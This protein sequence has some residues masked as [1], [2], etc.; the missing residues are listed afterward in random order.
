[1]FHLCPTNARPFDRSSSSWAHL[2][3]GPVPIHQ[4]HCMC[5]M[6]RWWWLINPYNMSSTSIIANWVWCFV[7]HAQRGAHTH[8]KRTAGAL[9]L[10]GSRNLI[11]L[12]DGYDRSH[13]SH[14]ANVADFV[15]KYIIPIWI[16]SSQPSGRSR[17]H[18]RIRQA[19][20]IR[21]YMPIELYHMN[22]HNLS[23]QIIFNFV[24]NKNIDA[25]LPS[26]G[27]GVVVS[28]LLVIAKLLSPFI[29]VCALRMYAAVG[30]GQ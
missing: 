28:A 17:Y 5:V 23:V 29:F 24:F 4:S 6:E 7:A 14:N 1:M 18:H 30:V 26:H 10:H 12:H 19:S 9:V 22:Y 27:G 8:I 16:P 15:N 11:A 21:V 20:I 3:S 13:C 25:M 2:N